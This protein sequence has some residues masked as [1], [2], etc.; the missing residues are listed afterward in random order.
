MPA[1]ARAN[2]VHEGQRL[3]R[4]FGQHT[5]DGLRDRGRDAWMDPGDWGWHFVHVSMQERGY[6][7][8]FERWA[9]GKK[10]VSD[11]SKR[12]PVGRRSNRLSLDLL[13]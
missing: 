5:G 1:S 2:A 13:G 3:G 4:V 11:D 12:I 10:F 7:L 9:A 8:T 6:G